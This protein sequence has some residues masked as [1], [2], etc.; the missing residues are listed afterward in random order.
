M[1][2]VPCVWRMIDR[3]DLLCSYEYLCFFSFYLKMTKKDTTPTISISH[4]RYNAPSLSFV[5][6]FSRFR[7]FFFFYPTLCVVVVLLYCTCTLA[8]FIFFHSLTSHFTSLTDDD[9]FFSSSSF[10]S[11]L[12]T[13]TKKQQNNDNDNDNVREKLRTG[14]PGVQGPGG[15]DSLTGC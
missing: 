13:R 12:T 14:A 6:L 4:Y 15:R 8:S 9:D 7:F 1:C 5:R 10:S 3:R 2:G 11:P